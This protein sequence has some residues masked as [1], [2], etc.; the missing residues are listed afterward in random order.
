MRH[1]QTIPREAMST[2]SRLSRMGKGTGQA[3]P[4]DM[5]PGPL[6]LLHN[7]SGVTLQSANI[8][9]DWITF[10]HHL[11]ELRTYNFLQAT[12]SSQTSVRVI[13]GTVGTVHSHLEE[14]KKHPATP[15][16][17]PAQLSLP[18]VQLSPVLGEGRKLKFLR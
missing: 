3:C 12:G 7:C 9:S 1:W 15:T 4:R 10:I 5:V 14:T 8:F 17:T 13:L 11:W 6:V 18:L 16:P 2:E